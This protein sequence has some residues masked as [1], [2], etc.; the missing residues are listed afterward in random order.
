[1]AIKYSIE[2]TYKLY[3]DSTGESWTVRQFTGEDLVELFYSAPNN[4]P[5]P[6]VIMTPAEALTVA[7]LLKKVAKEIKDRIDH[8]EELKGKE[9]ME[10]VLALARVGQ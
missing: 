5:N 8:E 10:I 1:M 4:T 9:A 6:A 3:N 2:P 7:N